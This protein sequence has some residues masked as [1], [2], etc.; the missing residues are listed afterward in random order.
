MEKTI[1]RLEEADLVLLV[2]DATKPIPVLPSSVEAA[3]D[4]GRWV[5]VWNKSDLP[6]G[7]ATAPL[8]SPWSDLV[9]VNLSAL[10]GEGVEGLSDAIT[11]KADGVGLEL[12]AEGL[13]VN[14]RHADALRRARE[15][16]GSAAEKLRAQGPIELIS[17]DLRGSLDA[18]GEIGGRID[19]EAMLDRLFAS[20]CI[21][22]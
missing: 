2:V 17:S 16:L 14:A 5:L 9:A 7:K 22:K 20:F 10:T 18:F 13:T 4:A 8:P 19:N 15:C 3:V 11:R 21:G 12:G 6:G 1:E